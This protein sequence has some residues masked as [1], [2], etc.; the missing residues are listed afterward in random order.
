MDSPVF[1]A[2]IGILWAL[3]IYFMLDQGEDSIQTMLIRV[4]VSLLLIYGLYISPGL[5]KLIPGIVLG[6]MWGP[7]VAKLAAGSLVDDLTGAGGRP[8]DKPFY[9]VAEGKRMRGDLEGAMLAINEELRKFPG[10]FDGQ[11]LLASIQAENQQNFDAATITIENLL[12]QSQ[13]TPSNISYALNTLA[14]WKLK[15]RRDTDGA[16]ASLRRLMELYP[17]TLIE[18]RTAQRLA[19]LDESF[20]VNDPRDAGVVVSECLKHLEVHPLDNQA[21]E[22]L[23]RVYFKRHERTDLAVAELWR[24]AN[25]PHQS[26]DDIFKWLNLSADWLLAVGDQSGAEQCLEAII[27][28]YPNRSVGERAGHRLA[29]LRADAR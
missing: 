26:V 29:R 17:G 25:T 23:A 28:R 14:D 8:D 18:L 12:H 27:K 20:E 3:V 10:D 15:Y 2:I 16:R 21:R 1:L 9:S 11:M 19:R 7:H 24:L 5:V 13:H 22:V 4:G 6:M